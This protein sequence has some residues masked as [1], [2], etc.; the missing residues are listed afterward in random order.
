MQ[1]SEEVMGHHEPFKDHKYHASPI[2]Q[3][4][5]AA[6]IQKENKFPECLHFR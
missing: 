4:D 2:P 1:D 5:R 3:L 6:T